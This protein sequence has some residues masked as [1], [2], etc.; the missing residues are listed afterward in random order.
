MD[1]GP[2]FP[3]LR[4]AQSLNQSSRLPPER[5]AWLYAGLQIFMQRQ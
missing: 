3:E 5:S 1:E 4:V 2:Y